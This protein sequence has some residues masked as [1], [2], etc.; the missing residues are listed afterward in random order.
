MKLFAAVLASLLATSTALAE[1]VT[2]TWTLPTTRMDGTALPAS[3]LVKTTVVYG[4]CGTNDVAQIDGSM[5]V[6]SPGATV[7]FDR[8]PGEVCVKANVT[9]TEGRVSDWSAV[10][11]GDVKSDSPPGAPIIIELAYLPKPELTYVVY[12]PKGYQQTVVREIVN[13]EVVKAPGNNLVATGSPCNCAISVMG[14]NGDGALWCSVGGQTQKAVNTS[15]GGVP[16]GEAFP[17]SYASTCAPGT[18]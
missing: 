12:S 13:G 16:K 18:V 6:P 11:Y 14:Y 9:D 5:D 17:E 3:E 7:Q 1:T 4:T 2:V 15:E 10:A 8:A